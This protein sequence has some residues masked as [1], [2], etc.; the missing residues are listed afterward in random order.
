MRPANPRAK[1]PASSGP[2][3]GYR[4]DAKLQRPKSRAFHSEHL[5][6]VPIPIALEYFLRI[7]LQF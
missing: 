1:W 6:V 2:S 7:V 5:P 3:H 4:P